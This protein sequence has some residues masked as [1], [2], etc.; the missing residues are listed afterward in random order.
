M[1]ILSKLNIDKA[2]RFEKDIVQTKVINGILYV[3]DANNLFKIQNEQTKLVKQNSQFFSNA[4][5]LVE[6]RIMS[7]HLKH[8]FHELVYEREG[9]FK[10]IINITKKEKINDVFLFYN[11]GCA[12]IEFDDGTIDIYLLN[13][14]KILTNLSFDKQINYIYKSYTTHEL[15]IIL[16]NK[17]L[18]LDMI[19]LK[20][21]KEIKINTKD[22]VGVNYINKKVYIIYKRYIKILS[23][24]LSENIISIDINSDISRIFV[25]RGLNEI[26][27]VTKSN[28]ILLYHIHTNSIFSIYVYQKKIQDIRFIENDFYVVSKNLISVTNTQKGF[29]ELKKYLLLE[30]ISSSLQVLQINYF[31]I[32]DNYIFNKINSFWIDS[33]KIIT[34]KLFMNQINA[35]EDIFNKFSFITSYKQDY[36]NILLSK[37]V[38]LDISSSLRRLEY[39]NVFQLLESNQFLKTTPIG[40]KIINDW[41]FTLN[42]F[43]LY[44]LQSDFD[45]NS[46]E[47]KAIKKYEVDSS[48]KELIEIIIENQ[49]IILTAVNAYKNKNFLVYSMLVE[50]YKFFKHLPITKNLEKISFGIYNKALEYIQKENFDKALEAIDLLRDFH[51]FKDK[52]EILKEKINVIIGFKSSYEREDITRC[53]IFLEQYEE[54]FQYSEYY[55]NIINKDLS[56]M[57]LA[58]VQIK[59]YK[60][61]SAYKI[62][63]EFFNSSI[64]GYKVKYIMI[65]YYKQ[66]FKYNLRY[67]DSNNIKLYINNFYKLFG[68]VDK[69]FSSYSGDY[70]SRENLHLRQIKL[71][72]FFPKDLLDVKLK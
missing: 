6:N 18:F 24:D 14:N 64:W 23:N 28:E 47:Y 13:E 48:K 66:Q 12:A 51:S 49:H 42:K 10:V 46:K 55:Y 59:N 62:L 45:E 67:H 26:I 17:I 70:N 16:E 56:N 11:I 25:N 37:H 57:D 7:I 33:F 21:N 44:I 1:A 53:R 41:D 63:K 22:F 9:I 27:I 60:L 35:A 58:I 34:N 71:V 19:T 72:K 43:I 4:F 54:H 39:D 36:E 5:D 38:F 2:Y 65:E 61:E 3:F 50:K 32:L 31:L 8:N 15:I 29:L 69:S 40:Q 20:T 30:D 52:A 68:Y